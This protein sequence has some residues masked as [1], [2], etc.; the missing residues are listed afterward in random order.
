MPKDIELLL[1][2]LKLKV[3][4]GIAKLESVSI[5]DKKFGLLLENI[6]SASNL[7]AS[8][9]SKLQT[10]T[11]AMAKAQAEKMAAAKAEA[12]K[13]KNDNEK[14]EILDVNN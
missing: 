5:D 8:I 14:E 6:L 2:T 13:R 9:E 11:Q 7:V 3:S 10:Q 4:S 1:K 12:E